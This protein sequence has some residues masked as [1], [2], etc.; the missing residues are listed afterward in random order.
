MTA[1]LI[2]TISTK[3]RLHYLV[4]SQ[5]VSIKPPILGRGFQHEH[6]YR[7]PEQGIEAAERRIDSI[8][9]LTVKGGKGSSEDQVSEFTPV[10]LPRRAMLFFCPRG[11]H[12]I[13]FQGVGHAV[14]GVKATKLSVRDINAV[15]WTIDGWRYLLFRPAAKIHRE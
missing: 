10:S 3:H 11:Y 15:A 1:R 4:G 9:I 8:L 5:R 6:G 2:L 13:R 7:E 14:V 12:G